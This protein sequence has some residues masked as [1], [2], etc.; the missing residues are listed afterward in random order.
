MKYFSVFIQKIINYFARTNKIHN[1]IY[2]DIQFLI[3]EYTFIPLKISKLNYSMMENYFIIKM[4]R[5][6]A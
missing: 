3:T 1:F 4:A 5:G 6:R 2:L